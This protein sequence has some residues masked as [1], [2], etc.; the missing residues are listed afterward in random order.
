MEANEAARKLIALN[1]ELAESSYV[2][3]NG[4]IQFKDSMLL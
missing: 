1:G 4:L 3:D 2:D